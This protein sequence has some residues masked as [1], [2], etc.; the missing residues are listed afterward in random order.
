VSLLANRANSTD[1]SERRCDLLSSEMHWLVRYARPL[2]FLLIADFLCMIVGSALSLLD[3]LVV[4]WLIDVALP[5]HTL[6]PVLLGTLIFCLIYLASLGINYLASFLSCLITQKMVFRI[7]MSVL[8]RLHVLPARYH[9]DFQLGDTLYRIEE[10]V[11]RVAELSGDILPLTIQML[12]MGVMVLTTMGILN[13]RLTLLVAPMLPVF[14]F[15]QRTYAGKLKEAA[16]KAQHQSG[17]VNAF[18]QEH[19]AGL[20]QLQL[21]NRASTE[22]GKFARLTAKRVQLQVQ[23]R[24]TEMAF[25]A[26]SVSAIVLGVGLILGYGGYEVNRGLLT[27]G[28][29]VAFYGY[30]FRLFA[31]VSIAIDLQS[32][33]QR[34]GASIR[35]VVEMTNPQLPSEG[36]GNA[37]PVRRDTKP[38]LEFRSVWFSYE[39]ERSV[40]RNMSFRIE[41]EE[42]V[43]LV[44]LNGSGK[45]TI[46]FLAT[47][48]YNPDSGS[49]VV[50]GSDT[51]EVSGRSLR[52]TISLVP[53]DPILF[54][55]TIRGNLLYGNPLATSSD[56]D[57]VAALTQLD[58]VLRRL[59][60][61]L[62][63]PLGPLGAKL[64]G[65]EKKRLALA[66]TLLQQPRILI[67]D[68]ITSSLDA[69]S[70]TA[71]LH[72]LEHFRRSRT[73]V[74]VS[75]RPST[76]L[77]AD[78]ILVVEDG[79]IVDS[80][81]HGDLILR[82]QA[83]RRIWQS[84]DYETPPVFD[85]ADSPD[86]SPV[87][88]E[89]R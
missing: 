76:I 27:V 10:D 3:P 70:A 66:R 28:G 24:A 1:M 67:V 54:D 9:R 71:L 7:R 48:L 13:W 51:Q 6:R 35:R 53:Q 61:G 23:Q 16:D 68:E 83:Y 25:G 43:A 30:I 11:D 20:V 88:Q 64:S 26:A 77:W 62:D 38:E 22:A 82:C 45:S 79:A 42:T 14:Y 69:P 80:G 44:G 87:S 5:R 18:L 72:G 17:R 65:G 8:R 85:R 47:G 39:K 34:V 52:A 55:E 78:R 81:R 15:L 32:R 50:G 37:V 46:G 89:A 74:V 4:K 86:W 33:L 58:L 60:K 19:L 31:P 57:E 73:L 59:P 75:H 84:Q 63:E 56:L 36:R 21:L 12:I 2:R 41:P 40:L 49:I 29:L